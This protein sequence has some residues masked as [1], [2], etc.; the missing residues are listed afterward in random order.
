M[1]GVTALCKGG[2]LG[3]HQ[4]WS[5]LCGLPGIFT[6][7]WPGPASLLPWEQPTLS[8]AASPRHEAVTPP[9]LEKS[10]S[11]RF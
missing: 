4:R 10:S 1:V 6:G 2:H 7:D 9:A 3:E 11:L 8:P 5:L